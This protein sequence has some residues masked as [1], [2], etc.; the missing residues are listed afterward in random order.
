MRFTPFNG[1]FRKNILRLVNSA[2]PLYTGNYMDFRSSACLKHENGTL[3]E[4]H[5]IE[6]LHIA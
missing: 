2:S 6:C 4:L 1:S 5:L 3:I